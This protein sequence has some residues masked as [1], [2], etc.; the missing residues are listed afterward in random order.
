MT[1]KINEKQK[2]NKKSLE[3]LNRYTYCSSENQPTSSVQ[4]WGHS[5]DT[6]PASSAQQKGHSA[7]TQPAFIGLSEDWQPQPSP[8]FLS[9]SRKFT[10]NVADPK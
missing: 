4:Q 8:I 6:Q 10:G 7:E 5:V 1:T 9:H 3:T 2:S